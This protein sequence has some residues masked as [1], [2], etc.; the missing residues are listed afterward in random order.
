MSTLKR[1]GQLLKSA[2][3]D[4]VHVIEEALE[5]LQLLRERTGATREWKR[6]EIGLGREDL[7]ATL[8]GV[9]D[10]A[11]DE[12]RTLEAEYDLHPKDLRQVDPLLSRIDDLL[13]GRI[14]Q[15]YSSSELRLLVE[16]AHSFRFPNEIPPGFLDANKGSQLRA[17]GDFILWRQTLDMASQIPT[18]E[19]LILLI[20]Q[21]LKADWW[22]LDAK[23]RPKGP[24][25]EL[26][27]EMRDIA[28][29]DLLLVTLKEFIAGTKEHLSSKVSNEA[30]KDLGEFDEDIDS[31]LPEIFANAKAP[32]N[33]LELDSTTFERLIHYLLV[34]MGYHAE[35]MDIGVG[36]RGYDFIA[37]SPEDPSKKI[38]VQTKRSLGPSSTRQVY[39][40]VG[41]LR[42]GGFGGALFFSTSEFTRSAR[43]IATAEGIE[44][45]GGADLTRMLA[46]LGIDITISDPRYT[47]RDNDPRGPW[48]AVDI[49]SPI[50]RSDN[51]YAITRPDGNEIYPPPGRGWR[52]PE[53]RFKALENDG[54]IYW[55]NI[56]SGIPRLK[57]FLSE[58]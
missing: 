38:I 19:R 36:D 57:R 26:T 37:A 34:R 12:F 20:T 6:E 51:H 45:V 14:G 54:R 42:S 28:G 52:F 3:V 7:L 46:E 9:I 13:A 4:A 41:V 25:P 48:L 23:K 58:R 47:N 35:R 16:E 56:L 55:G 44:I 50:A 49:T 8:E 2:T 27:Q 43:E 11:I 39:E 15:G 30:I 10:S 1:T 53:E 29:A 17:A 24:L 18:G 31:L 32:L 40:L 22:E 33:I 21:D 5:K